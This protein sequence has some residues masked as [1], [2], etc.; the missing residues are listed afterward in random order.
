MKADIRTQ[1]TKNV[2]RTCFFELL[3]ETPINKITVKA[4]CDK[5]N[6]NRTTFYRHY[7]DPYDLMDQIENEL[8]EAFRSHVSSHLKGME[9]IDMETALKGMFSAILHNHETYLILISENA[10]RFYIRKM[11]TE[12][13]EFFKG[14]ME[15]QYPSLSENQ[16]RWLYYYI[17]QGSTG[18]TIDWLER[19][20]KESPDEM[21]KFTAEIN[22]AVLNQRYTLL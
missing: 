1:F 16:R 20:T 3:K 17:A 4:I 9:K 8:L 14:A 12:T 22:R 21:A 7:R 10:D 11:I 19:G 2:I 5:A 15:K 18:I 6:I 13:Y